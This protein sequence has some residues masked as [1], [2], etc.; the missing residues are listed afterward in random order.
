MLAARRALARG[1]ARHR[2]PPW[3]FLR[4]DFGGRPGS[5]AGGRGPR[6][7][8]GG[9][10]DYVFDIGRGLVGVGDCSPGRSWMRLL[11]YDMPPARHLHTGST[12]FSHAPERGQLY[13]QALYFCLARLQRRGVAVRSRKPHPLF[14]RLRAG[15][16]KEGGGSRIPASGIALVESQSPA[17]GRVGVD[18]GRPEGTRR[19]GGAGQELVKLMPDTILRQCT[20]LIREYSIRNG[21]CRVDGEYRAWAI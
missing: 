2:S 11:I 5:F 9:P 16:W 17:R 1:N 4:G 8:R 14:G 13:E 20:G 19:L 18:R 3:R 10:S 6:L 12:G 21:P 7:T 15:V